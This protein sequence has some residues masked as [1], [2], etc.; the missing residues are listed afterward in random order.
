[1]TDAC[2]TRKYEEKS[3]CYTE[4]NVGK[5]FTKGQLALG[6]VLMTSFFRI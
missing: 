3:Y 4:E 5:A 1:M 6:L 2:Y